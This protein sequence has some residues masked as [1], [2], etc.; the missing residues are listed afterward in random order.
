[1][2]I[3]TLL[4]IKG[5]ANQDAFSLVTWTQTLRPCLV[6]LY[7]EPFHLLPERKQHGS[8]TIEDNLKGNNKGLLRLSPDL[9]IP[10]SKNTPKKYWQKKCIR[11]FVVE[12]AF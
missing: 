5:H 10:C 9:A 12:I 7:E 11:H 8:S 4:L 3:F 2:A 6:K 1:M